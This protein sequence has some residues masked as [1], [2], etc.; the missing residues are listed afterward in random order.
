MPTRGLLK[1]DDPKV[2]GSISSKHQLLLGSCLKA[3]TSGASPSLEELPLRMHVRNENEPTPTSHCRCG[4]SACAEAFIRWMQAAHSSLLY[5]SRAH[6]R[7]PLLASSSCFPRPQLE[8]LA[9]S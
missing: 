9:L 8:L 2:Q 3:Q 7:P 1:R 4:A 6:S 5:R